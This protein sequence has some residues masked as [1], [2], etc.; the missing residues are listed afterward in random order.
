MTGPPPDTHLAE[1]WR[2]EAHH[3]DL[4][5]G[6]ADP[7]SLPLHE[8]DVWRAAIV[9]AAGEVAGRPVL[10]LG[11]GTGD[12]TLHLVARGARLTALDISPGMVELVRERIACHLQGREARL[13]VAPAEATGLEA[14]SFDLVVGTYVIHHVDVERAAAEAARLLRP[15]GRCLFVEN[16]GLNPVLNVA[17]R[18]LP[19]RFGINRCGTADEHPLRAADYAV[20]ARHFRRVATHHVE[21]MCFR[22]IARNV[23]RY[24]VGAVNWLCHQIDCLAYRVPFLRRFSYHVLVELER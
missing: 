3:H 22:L 5:A 18:Y 8:L 21:L 20:F 12:L 10:E 15:G 13:L 2:R 6:E 23:F 14:G 16:S 17:R 9:E 24:R 7:R 4:Q 19:G 1:I 11:C